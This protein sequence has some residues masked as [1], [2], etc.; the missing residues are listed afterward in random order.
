[1]QIVVG[2]GPVDTHVVQPV[3]GDNLKFVANPTDTDI[4]EAVGR[5][6]F[7]EAPLEPLDR[8]GEILG[9]AEHDRRLAEIAQQVGQRQHRW[10]LA[11]TAGHHH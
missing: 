6:C 9:A 3:L 4:A 5:H 7:R 1:M 8:E 10:R 11:G 2:L